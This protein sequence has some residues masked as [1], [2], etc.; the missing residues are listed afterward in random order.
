MV[1]GEWDRF[2]Y[3]FAVLFLWEH[4]YYFEVY[5]IEVKFAFDDKKASI[6]RYSLK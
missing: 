6:E 3:Q 4:F 5:E 2:K 1:S